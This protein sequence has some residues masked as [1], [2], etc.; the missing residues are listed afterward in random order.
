MALNR[1]LEGTTLRDFVQPAAF[2]ADITQNKDLLTFCQAR[3]GLN[4]AQAKVFQTHLPVTAPAGATGGTLRIAPADGK[5][6]SRRLARERQIRHPRRHRHRAAAVARG[7]GA[8]KLL[9]DHGGKL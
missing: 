9:I 1:C 6:F 2:A 7:I 4:I 5:T 3:A 8:V